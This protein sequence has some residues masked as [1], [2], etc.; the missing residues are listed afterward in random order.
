MISLDWIYPSQHQR[1][2]S[3]RATGVHL[4]V[5]YSFLLLSVRR[6]TIIVVATGDPLL[7][8]F[9][10]FVKRDKDDALGAVFCHGSI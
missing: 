10:G 7:F 2:N 1:N 5:E 9:L 6:K 4:L 8:G 3:V